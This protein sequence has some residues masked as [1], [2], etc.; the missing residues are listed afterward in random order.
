[1][2]PFAFAVPTAF[3]N[4]PGDPNLNICLS[5]A[6]LDGINTPSLLQL[7]FCWEAAQPFACNIANLKSAIVDQAA[8]QLGLKILTSNVNLFMAVN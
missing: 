1:M 3:S 2:E 4:T 7:T 8:S 6:A 5:V